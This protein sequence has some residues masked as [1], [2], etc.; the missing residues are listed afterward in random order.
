MIWDSLEK[1]RDV[2]LLI[3]RLGFGLGFV[4]FHGWDKL[5]GGPERWAGNG[6]VMSNIGIDFG[7]TFFGLMAA[8]S[9]SVG[10]L[11]IAA[12]LFFRPVCAVLAFTMVMAT[13][14]H[15]VSG[16]GNPGHAVKNFFVLIGLLFVG[17]GKYSLD[18]WIAGKRQR[19]GS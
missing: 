2:G 11:M 7:H 13:M 6:A 18:A 14:S 10:G 9:E 12:G 16:R 8:L 15:F 19:G 1:Y 17:P 5:S 4:F 3:I